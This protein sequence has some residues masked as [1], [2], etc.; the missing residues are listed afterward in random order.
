[1]RRWRSREK[2]L[3]ELGKVRMC[4]EREMGQF[5]IFL[6]EKGE[7]GGRISNGNEQKGKSEDSC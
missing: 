6:K 1:M 5:C 2:S 3:A 7:P 4:S